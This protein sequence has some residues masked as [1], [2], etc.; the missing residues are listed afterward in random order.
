[1]LH[2]PPISSFLTWSFWLYLET[3]TSYEAFYYAAFSNLRPLHPSLV[4]L[5]SS[6]PCSAFTHRIAWGSNT[7]D[8]SVSRCWGISVRVVTRLWAGRPRDR[9]SFS[10]R[11]RDSS[12]AHSVQI[13][14]RANPACSPTDNGYFSRA[15]AART[16]Y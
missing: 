9:G 8:S 3:S 7:Y 1:V 6:T 11:S 4:Q 12:H 10:G 2:A 16:W 14:S 15:K 5:F 13:G